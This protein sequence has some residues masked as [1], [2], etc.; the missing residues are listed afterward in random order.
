MDGV[1]ACY[2]FAGVCGVLPRSLSL[3]KLMMMA[4]GPI[5]QRRI[6]TVNLAALV[7]SLGSVDVEKYIHF[8]FIEDTG[9]GGPVRL[10][11][12]LQAKVDAEVERRRQTEPDLP[13]ARRG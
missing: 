6:E 2:Y 11:D 7:W 1:E 4:N 3:R 12:E 5:K 13:K 8:G 9:A 10:S